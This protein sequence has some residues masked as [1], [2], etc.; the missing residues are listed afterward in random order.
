MGIKISNFHDATTNTTEK[1]NI[2]L[3]LI[4]IKRSFS[5]AKLIRIIQ[6]PNPLMF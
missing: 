3:F 1:Y 5:P 4:A 2:R 6:L